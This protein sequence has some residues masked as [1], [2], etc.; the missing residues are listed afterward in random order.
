MQT[1]ECSS[2]QYV[3]AVW[4]AS[5]GVGDH[6]IFYFV[7]TSLQPLGDDR[8]L[9]ARQDKARQGGRKWN[10]LGRQVLAPLPQRL[11]TM[12]ACMA[13]FNKGAAP[14]VRSLC[15][16]G[17]NSCFNI[18]V[19]HRSCSSSSNNNNLPPDIIARPPGCPMWNNA[20]SNWNNP[21][22]SANQVIIIIIC[23]AAA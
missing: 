20:T 4:A 15:G 2:T 9:L 18:P 11:P 1:P 23:A 16:R 10:E 14:G 3:V 12:G 21:M 5:L 19:V 22:E 13:T 7:C 8:G 6:R 17:T